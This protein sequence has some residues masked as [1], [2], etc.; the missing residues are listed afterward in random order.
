MYDHDHD[1]PL[2]FLYTDSGNRMYIYNK[3]FYL[4]SFIGSCVLVLVFF[5][6]Y[7]FFFHFL[8]ACL[9]LTILLWMFNHVEIKK[10]II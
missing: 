7:W 10:K 5:F 3:D 1:D 4:S 6:V 8:Y 9:K 2:H